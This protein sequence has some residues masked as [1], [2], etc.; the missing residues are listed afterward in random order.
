MKSSLDHFMLLVS[1]GA[2][3]AFQ[4]SLSGDASQ[5]VSQAHLQ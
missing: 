2:H 5:N 1:Q 4:H 3:W